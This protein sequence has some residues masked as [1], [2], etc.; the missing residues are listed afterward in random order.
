MNIDKN[1][2]SNLLSEKGILK[3]KPFNLNDNTEIYAYY[4]EEQGKS[5]FHFCDNKL[6]EL[7]RNDIG[8]KDGILFILGTKDSYSLMSEYTHVKGHNGQVIER[9]SDDGW[10]IGED[11]V[12][13]QFYINGYFKISEYRYVLESSIIEIAK[14]SILNIWSPNIHKYYTV[15]DAKRDTLK[16]DGKDVCSYYGSIKSY[17]IL[18]DADNGFF[19]TNDNGDIIHSHIDSI[20]IAENTIKLISIEYGENS[21]FVLKD[22]ESDNIIKIRVPII[23]HNS[24]GTH[25]KFYADNET[26]CCIYRQYGNYFD[27][28]NKELYSHIFTINHRTILYNGEF[29]NDDEILNMKNGILTVKTT[30]YVGDSWCPRSLWRAVHKIHFFDYQ[31]VKLGEANSIKEQ[32]VVVNRVYYKAGNDTLVK[33][34]LYG[35]LD[36]NEMKLVIPIRYDNI[37]MLCSDNYLCVI[38]GMIKCDGLS[39]EYGLFCNNNLVLPINNDEIILLDK[40]QCNMII[41]WKRDSKYGLICNGKICLSNIFQSI[42]IKNGNII[43]GNKDKIGFYIPA[44]E[45]LSPIQFDTISCIRNNIVI[46]DN[47]IF[48]IIGNETKQLTAFDDDYVYEDS[49][50]EHYM[51]KKHELSRKTSVDDYIC[52]RVINNTIEEVAVEDLN[53]YDIDELKGYNIR[54]EKFYIINGYLYYNVKNDCFV[55]LEDMI[56]ED[57]GSV[58]EDD[59]DYERDTFYALGGEDYDEWK[60]N[61]GN[62]DDM[63]DGMGF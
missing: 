55:G 8:L 10:L 39:L 33:D 43:I 15:Y 46:A 20:W 59:Y 52:Y 45:Y 18:R 12:I 5:I 23:L 2:I 47:N 34:L 3:F 61:G 24:Y 1:V 14:E 21:F 60:N 40:S 17:H 35:V 53:P 28:Y 25:F 51:F 29:S 62:L 36:T 41:R 50:D 31:L 13:L 7:T 32:F 26:L 42:E 49:T 54:N 22:L 38:L 48:Q 58:Y 27:D 57:F 37:K 30:N 19:V 9:D 44:K 56:E 11:N 63:M 6:R 4:T 16:E